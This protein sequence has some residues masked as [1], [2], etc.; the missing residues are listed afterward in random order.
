MWRYAEVVSIGLLLAQAVAGGLPS[1]RWAV[2]AALAVLFVDAVRTMPADPD[3]AGYGWQVLQPGNDIPSGFESGLTASWASL[4]VC[5]ASL[6][7]VV[8]LLVAWRRGGLRRRTVAAAAVAAALVAGYA[9]VRVVDIWLDVRA[10][11]RRYPGGND[12]ADA[13]SA[14]GLAVLPPLALGLTALALAA[15]LAGHGRRLAST[16]AALLAVVAL[17][18][19]DASIGAVPLPFYAGD[20]TALFTWDAITP[21]LSLPQPV[22]AITA[23]VEL[24]AYLLIVTGLTGSHRPTPA[25]PA[26]PAE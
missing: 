20:R 24:A 3:A 5:W 21:T 17:P 1:P 26:P 8:L 13:V 16:G 12:S 22:P 11:H 4:T 18:Q 2:P 10:E 14:A 19:L 9:V 15:A 6:T 23:A 7:A 25:A